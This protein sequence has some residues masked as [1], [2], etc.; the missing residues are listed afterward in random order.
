M[1]TEKYTNSH[2]VEIV[3]HFD[4]LHYQKLDIVDHSIFY[5]CRGWD[6]NGTQYSGVA[7]FCCDEFEGISDIEEL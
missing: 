1:T 3:V 4:D 5:E 2:G 6:V 7:E